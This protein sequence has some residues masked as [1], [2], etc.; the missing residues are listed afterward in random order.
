MCFINRYVQSSHLR[1]RQVLN[2]G[3][4]LVKNHEMR[5]FLHGNVKVFV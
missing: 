1:H 4:K 2:S 5:N 3:A